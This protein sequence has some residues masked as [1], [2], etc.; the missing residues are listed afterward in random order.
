MRG[1][2]NISI[3]LFLFSASIALLF[4]ELLIYSNFCAFCKKTF[5][6]LYFWTFRVFVMLFQCTE[7]WWKSNHCW[8]VVKPLFLWQ[9]RIERAAD[10]CTALNDFPCREALSVQCCFTLFPFILPSLLICS[11]L[12][13]VLFFLHC[14]HSNPIH[15]SVTWG[16]Q[17]RRTITLPVLVPHSR[18]TTLML[19]IE[20]LYFC[21]KFCSWQYE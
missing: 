11:L 1:F 19:K 3:P 8:I 9:A 5:Q 17:Q 12:W 20:P 15:S 2:L 6:E 21:E 4:K 10:F 13:G 16:R 7:A 18:H 14:F